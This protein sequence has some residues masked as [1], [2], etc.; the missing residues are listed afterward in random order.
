MFGMGRWPGAS[1][2]GRH[3]KVRGRMPMRLGETRSTGSRNG[4]ESRD[5]RTREARSTGS[6][7]QG[8][9]DRITQR[10]LLPLVAA[11][12][13]NRTQAPHHLIL[14]TPHVSLHRCQHPTQQPNICGGRMPM[15]L[16]ETKKDD[17]LLLF[18]VPYSTR[19]RAS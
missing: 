7:K 16:G 19:N 13:E 5:K 6:R 8:L 18:V 9:A 17:W 10:N 12:K 11:E 15:R 4:W 14:A 3:T 1:S 2:A